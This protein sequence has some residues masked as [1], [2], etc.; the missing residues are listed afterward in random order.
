MADL[1]QQL[2]QACERYVDERIAELTASLRS[3]Q[4]SA[5]EETKSSSGDKY[6]TGRA[7][8]HLEIEKL[9]F[10][11]VE[12]NRA[13]ADLHRIVI[14][15][16]ATPIKPGSVVFTSRGNFFIS[17]HAGET[18]INNTTFFLI[19]PASPVAQKMMGLNAQSEFTL[20]GRAFTILS[21]Q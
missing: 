11:L 8:A 14:T 7:M 18:T 15:L 2:Y 16:P 20:N 19:S 21:V 3:I 10:Q 9:Q 13:K 4:Q 17:I 12:L 5:N 1:K 6:E